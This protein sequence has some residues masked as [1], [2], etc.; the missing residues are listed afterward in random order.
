MLSN[1]NQ[2]SIQEVT[3]DASQKL[4][5]IKTNFKIDANTVNLK[6]VGLYNYDAAKLENYK[7]SVDGKNIYIKMIDYPSNNSRYYLKVIGIKDALGRTLSATYDDYI[8]FVNDIKTKVEI[9]SPVS[10]ETL[11]EREV[12]ICLR[13]TN[14][15]SDVK[16]RIE[17]GIDN[18]FFGKVST[19]I[20]Q[21][22]NEYQN[23]SDVQFLINNTEK[24]N[25]VLTDS[26]GLPIAFIN[27]YY[28]NDELTL[29][30]NID[31]EGQ[32]YIRARAESSISDSIV[33]DWSET[34]S[35]NILTIT[36]DSLETT[37]LEEYLTTDEL[38]DE[39]VR[40]PVEIVD[41]TEIATTDSV[42]FLEFNKDIR[43]PEDYKLTQDGYIKFGTI[44]AKR[45]E[46][47]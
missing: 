8:K 22:P 21:I 19:M 43:L 2:F 33:G 3:P 14:V 47:K 27:G 36:M 13:L 1:F 44:M 29:I 32:V 5:T 24:E 42:F 23:K 31:R 39:S 25:E 18:V 15:S 26:S 10:R 28:R 35:F 9:I 40:E 30:T 41:K 20:C 4:I 16:Y 34:I 11:K 38:F 7:L 37:F 17:I 45:K 6:S 12:N 46:M